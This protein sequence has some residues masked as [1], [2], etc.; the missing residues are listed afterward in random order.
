[1]HT[2]T[3]VTANKIKPLL[4]A[5]CGCFFTQKVAGVYIAVIVDII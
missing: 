5:A 3:S 4:Y 2:F 1:M